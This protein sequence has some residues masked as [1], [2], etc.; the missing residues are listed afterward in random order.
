MG[1]MNMDLDFNPSDLQL[2]AGLG[3]HLDFIISD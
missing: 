1:K 3:L 2:F